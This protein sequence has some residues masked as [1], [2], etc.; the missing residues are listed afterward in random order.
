MVTTHD[1]DT[2]QPRQND[3]PS[4]VKLIIHH[5][6]PGIEL[7]SSLC[8]SDGAV[9]HSSPDQRVD[10]GSTTQT[11]FNIDTVQNKSIGVLM[12][13]LH[14]KNT[15][16]SN[17]KAISSEETTCIQL[18][19]IWEVNRSKEF[20]VVSHLIE[21]DKSLVWNRDRLMK[22]AERYNAHHIQHDSIEDTW[23]IHDYTVLMTRVNVV[24]EEECYKLEMTISEAS[25]RDDT[26]IPRYTGMDK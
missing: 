13:N 3:T 11:G 4:K 8:Y 22:L 18:V 14:K 7:I 15:V 26:Q 10:V 23:I 20:Y 19:V 16:Q 9:C 25:I 5:Q 21:H 2:I 17:E 6:F 12:Y 1:V 24:C